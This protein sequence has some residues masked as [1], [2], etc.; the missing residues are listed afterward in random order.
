M[1]EGDDERIGEMV[2]IAVASRR[3]TRTL[4]RK[5]LERDA[6]TRAPAQL[7]RDTAPA[8]GKAVTRQGAVLQSGRSSETTH[9]RRDLAVV[10]KRNEG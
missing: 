3:V 10:T 2:P 7:I 1:T 8:V 4:L 9:G 5:M 6:G